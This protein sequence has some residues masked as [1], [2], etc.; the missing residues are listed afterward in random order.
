MNSL[1]HWLLLENLLF[2]YLHLDVCT[3]PEDQSAGQILLLPEARCWV[4]QGR[5]HPQCTCQLPS[6]Q[7]TWK[8]FWKIEIL[9][10]QINV[11]QI[12]KIPE[13]KKDAYCQVCF[14]VSKIKLFCLLSH[15]I[16]FLLPNIFFMLSILLRKL[17]KLPENILQPSC[18][19]LNWFLYKDNEK[20]LHFITFS[21][22]ILL[23]H[24]FYHA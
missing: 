13:T 24:T 19:K 15:E 16:M 23:D 10:M 18:L 6:N 14:L 11:L 3:G 5:G 12:H 9:D 8:S 7:Y 1:Q 21:Q 22:K 4:D 2:T 20:K 17:E